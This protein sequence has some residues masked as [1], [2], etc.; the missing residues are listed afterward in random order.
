MYIKNCLKHFNTVVTHKH[1][2]F[3]LCCKAGIPI[4][5]LIHDLS[6]FSPTE[7]LESAKYYQGNR[8]P[9][10]ACKET[11]GYSYGWLHHKSHNK[12]HPE[13]WVDRLSE[14]GFPIRMPYKYNVEMVCDIIAASITYNGTSFNKSMPY[15]YF[16]DKML[17]SSLMHKD[18]AKFTTVLLKHYATYG[19]VV[20]KRKSTKN[21]YKKYCSTGK[22]GW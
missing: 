7:F 18:T 16:V 9:I 21:L 12:H 5:G 2:V 1:E 13:Y 14:G 4:R 6:K 8:S 17:P 10:L 19:D 11:Q 3:K 15:Q 20:L 22:I